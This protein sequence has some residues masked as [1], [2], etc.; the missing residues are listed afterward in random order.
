MDYTWSESKRSL[1]GWLN[2]SPVGEASSR[3]EEVCANVTHSAQVRRPQLTTR[4]FISCVSMLVE[5]ERE[6]YTPEETKTTQP[7]APISPSPPLTH[8]HSLMA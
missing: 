7:V 1:V 4:A 6:I 2:A 8:P 3:I 5:R